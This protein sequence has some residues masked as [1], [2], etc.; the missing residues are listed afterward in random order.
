M[1]T[2]MLADLGAEVIKAAPDANAEPQDAARR[3]PKFKRLLI[4]MMVLCVVPGWTARWVL[5]PNTWEVRGLGGL[6]TLP[7]GQTLRVALLIPLER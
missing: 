4:A 5:S 1:S 2:K 7:S 3:I 6:P